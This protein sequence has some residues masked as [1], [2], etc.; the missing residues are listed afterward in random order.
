LV[1]VSLH[2]RRVQ[3]GLVPA[4]IRLQD[5]GVHILAVHPL[6]DLTGVQ[7]LI[8]MA[9]DRGVKLVIAAG[10]D[11]TISAAVN[12]MAYSDLALGVLPLGTSNDF[13]RSLGVPVDVPNACATIARAAARTIDLGLMRTDDGAQRYF[14]HAVTVGL[15]SKFARFATAAD[16]RKRY[17]RLA[18]PNAALR[19]L[20][21]RE[22]IDMCITTDHA[23]IHARILQ[24]NVLNAPI[25]G[26]AFQMRVPESTL[27]D[28]RLDLLLVGDVKYTHLL[29]ALRV[30]TS[31]RIRSVP[32]THLS[33]P[34]Y[35]RIE[36]EQL[37]DVVVD[38]EC[39]ART[40]VT[41]E[42]ADRALTVIG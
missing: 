16:W 38:G 29:Q 19:A 15:N 9:R 20:L 8:D 41:L 33:H 37:R 5:E 25:F 34:R 17:G 36:T 14:V 18:Y 12:C 24:A 23:E 35:I 28:R 1:V 2:A 22:A 26:G 4:L 6:R 10:G 3:T 31:K 42:S 21:M 11:G 32:Y 40:P 27:T 7:D 30:V 39:V 13:A